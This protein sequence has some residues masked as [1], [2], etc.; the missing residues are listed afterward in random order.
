MYEKL[1]RLREDLKRAERRKKSAD[2]KLKLAQDRLREAENAQIRFDVEALNLTPEQV[3]Q[4]LKMAASGQMDAVRSSAGNAAAE[5]GE[6][7]QEEG[8]AAG[9]PIKE[10]PEKE[11]TAFEEDEDEDESE[12]EEGKEDADD[13]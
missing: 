3:A 12:G 11:E 6:T 5:T 13:E 4:F 8:P 7:P 1:D 2:E 9:E 10:G